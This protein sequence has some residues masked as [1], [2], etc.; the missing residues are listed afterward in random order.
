[1][2]AQMRIFDK[3]FVTNVTKQS[4]YFV[5]N[6]PHVPDKVAPHTE[7]SVAF[8]ALEILIFSMFALHMILHIALIG[9]CN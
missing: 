8:S 2:S 6:I 7:E 4:F 3:S 9:K 1:M 5:V